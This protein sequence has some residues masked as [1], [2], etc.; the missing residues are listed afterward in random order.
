[1]RHVPEGVACRL[2]LAPH[3]WVLDLGMDSAVYQDVTVPEVV[4]RVVQETIG[5]VCRVDATVLTE[6][7]ETDEYLVQYQESSLNFVRRLMEREGI[8]LLRRLR[9]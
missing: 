3:L 1:M 5:G 2:L 8:L 6:S 4:S 9:G 7:Y